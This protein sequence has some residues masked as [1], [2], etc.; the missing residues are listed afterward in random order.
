MHRPPQAA[1]RRRAR[2]RSI[3]FER[4]EHRHLMYALPLGATPEDTG[5]YMLGRV[6]VVPVLFESNGQVDANTENWT[7]AEIDAVLAK[8]TEGVNWWSEALNRLGTVHELEFVV[9]DTYARTPFQTVYE[10]IARRSQDAP[11][12]ITPFLRANGV[13]DATS[14]ENAVHQFNHNARVRLGTD[15]AFTIFFAHSASDLDGSFGAGSEF[16]TAHAFAGGLYIVTPST[17]PASTITHETG[18]FLGAR[19]VS[20]WRELG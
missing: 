8:V 1:Q 11:L 7:P 13:E 4:L 15:W 5:E 18:H 12:Y 16:N 19:R 2:Q 3:Q 6:A 9:D 10:P 14:L 17:R 20:R